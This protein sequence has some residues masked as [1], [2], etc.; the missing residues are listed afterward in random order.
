MRCPA[1]PIGRCW[2][3]RSDGGTHFVV[4]LPSHRL[5][6]YITVML[7]LLLLFGYRCCYCSVTAVVTVMSPLLLL[8]G[9]RC[10][11]CSVTAVVTVLLPLRYCSA[12]AVVTVRLPLCYRYVALRFASGSPPWE[13]FYAIGA[14]LQRG[15]KHS[16]RLCRAA[17]GPGHASARRD[18]RP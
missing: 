13:S 9:Y 10:C 16:G 3:S 2:R 5:D 11:C 18:Q 6:R 8:F 1:V 7:P 17:A 12:T 15:G 4:V 14:A